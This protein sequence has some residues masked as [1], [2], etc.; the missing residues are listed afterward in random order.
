MSV[1]LPPTNATG[2]CD[3]RMSRAARRIILQVIVPIVEHWLIDSGRS[4]PIKRRPKTSTREPQS[5]GPTYLWDILQ[6][7][8][9]VSC[10]ILHDTFRDLEDESFVSPPRSRNFSPRRTY[11]NWYLCGICGK[12]FST[13]Y[14]LDRHQTSHPKSFSEERNHICLGN[15]ICDALGGCDHVALESEPHY[16]RGSGDGG[17]DAATVH[18]AWLSRIKPC[19]EER[20]VTFKKPNCIQL[21]DSCFTDD[22]LRL[23]LQ[24]KICEPLSCKTILHRQQIMHRY[25]L[26]LMWLEINKPS[27]FSSGIV[28]IVLLLFYLI[29]WIVV[30]ER[31][32]HGGGQTA[33]TKLLQK[34]KHVT[35]TW[36][37]KRKRA[38]GKSE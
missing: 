24:Q 30:Y 4:L 12:V 17:P 9:S 23:S 18:R 7:S 26:K 28:L 11:P 10:P 34:K 3:R 19:E 2:Y 36:L 35:G 33:G 38:K 32:S 25:D 5:L 13:R 14:Y 31:R 1:F 29:Y 22:L 6:L 16:G 20:I 15:L 21:M 8:A 37:T 27:R